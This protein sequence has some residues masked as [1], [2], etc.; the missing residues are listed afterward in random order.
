MTRIAINLEVP[1]EEADRVISTLEK[2]F[3]SDDALEGGDLLDCYLGLL[4]IE[5]VQIRRIWESSDGN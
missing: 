2:L 1:S 5:A 4:S 3:N